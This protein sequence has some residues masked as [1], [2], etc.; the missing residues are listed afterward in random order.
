[1][2]CGLEIEVVSGQLEAELGISGALGNADGA[3]IDI[4]GASTEIVVRANGSFAYRKSVDIGV[5]RLKDLCGADREMLQK[6]ANDFA[7]QFM[8]APQIKNLYAIG[9]TATTIAALT[10]GLKTYDSEK[11]TGTEISK[12][13]IGELAMRLRETPVEEI[14]KLPCMSTGRADVIA[15]GATLLF[16][17]LERLQIEK[18]IVSDRDN[19]EGYAIKRGLL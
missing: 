8:D 17:I 6:K 10:L 19:L 14:E 15:G 1:M 2:L 12:R 3:T 5:V 9:G 4:G 7:Q 13:G 18:I 11:V 16:S